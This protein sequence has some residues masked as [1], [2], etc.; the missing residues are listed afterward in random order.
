[1]SESH[2]KAVKCVLVLEI[3]NGANILNNRCD[4]LN[5]NETAVATAAGLPKGR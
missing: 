5:Q 2:G 1:M 3:V 4:E